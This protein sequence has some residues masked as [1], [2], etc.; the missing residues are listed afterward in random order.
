MAVKGHVAVGIIGVVLRVDT[1]VR[2]ACETIAVIAVDKFVDCRAVFSRPLQS[3]EIS[4]GIV[5]DAAF[6]EC[7]DRVTIPE[8]ASYESE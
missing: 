5:D 2:E 4:V 8:Q 3:K 1:T 6:I 7:I